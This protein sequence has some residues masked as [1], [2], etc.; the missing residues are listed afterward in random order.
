MFNE[1]L[2]ESFLDLVAGDVIARLGTDLANVVVVFPNIRAG[3]FF[4][5]SLYR[6]ANRPLW[7]PRYQSIESLF[8]S[9]ATL[10][11]G[12]NI[13]LTG[14]LYHTYI[15]VFNAHAAQPS[16][17]TLDEFFFF[18]EILLNDFDDVDKNLANVHSLFGNLQDLDRLK[19]DFAHLT[20]DQIKALMQ[21]FKHVFQ[22]ESVL[23]TAFH[24][25]WG[26]LGE[27]Y[28]TFKKKLETQ[29]I[30]YPG[31]LMRSVIENEENRFTGKQYVFA[32][33]NVLNRCE[34]RLFKQLK[35]K[36]LFY[37]DYDSYYLETEAGRFIKNNIRQ[38]GSALN[39][40]D[41]EVFSTK[42]KTITFLASPSENG[43]AAVVPLWIDSLN[44]PPSPARPD[45]AIV[46]C[47]EAILPAVM[48]AI[49]S[50]KVE[51]VNITMGFPIT[52][53]PVSSFLQALTEMQTL[54][55]Q[56]SGQSFRYKFVLPVLRHPY[57]TVLFPEAGAVER[58]IV[59]NNLFSPALDVLKN[60]LLFSFAEDTPALAAYLLA[61][62][63]KLG[64]CLG[65]GNTGAGAYNDLY[66]ESV[67]RAYQV[68]N[69]LSGLL[70]TGKWT[71]EKPT[72]LRLLRK[73]LST[74][75]IPFHGEPVKGL[76]I[77]GVL[78]TRS[79]DF[80]NILMLSVNEGFMPGSNSENTFIPQFLR[81]YFGLDT[82]DRQDSVY[83]YYFY[84]L[85]Q[86]AENLTF[87]YNTDKTQT[88]K[89]EISRFL[90]QLLIESPWKEKIVRRTL[91]S[92]VNPWTPQPI[93]I[94]KDG[95]LL[96][97]I[98]TQYDGTINPEAARLSPTAL[99]TLISCSFK[100][101]QQYIEGLRSK[102]EMS[103]ELD[104]SIFGSIFHRAAEYL[105][106]EIGH[107][108]EEIKKF[109]P[110]VV[111][112]EHFDPYLTAFYRIEK[113]VG[114]AFEREYF[115]GKPVN[116]QDFNGKQL[117][118]FRIIC[119]I[120]KRLIEFDSRR[121]PFT[122]H[123]LEYPVT[124]PFTLKNGIELKI[125]GIIDR[126]E[127]KDGSF[128]II[129]YKT[130]GKGKTYKTLEDLFIAKDNRASHIFQT[131]VYASALLQNEEFPL[132]IVPA[133]IYMQEA[134]KEDY[135]PVIL[136]NKEPIG[137]FRELNPEFEPLLKQ[138]IEA[139]FDPAIPFQQTEIA[140]VCEYCDFKEMCGRL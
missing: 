61:I 73:L 85:I 94:E 123:G 88:G 52:L 37:W 28:F 4:N 98:R 71:L 106:R 22:G 107:I 84:R 13:L 62:T 87:V 59:N 35:D 29:G 51:N 125:G 131:F 136:Y 66:V 99:N 90:L 68:I 140:G 116:P 112:K 114:R 20:D 129:D 6:Q 128:Y 75:K 111:R 26:I 124:S 103:D 74:V 47:N 7:A 65:K 113:L 67:F 32:G 40:P 31:M 95:N 96:Q 119:H 42:N 110:F 2:S 109:T 105:Y 57:T 83:A 97:R 86:R 104:N 24:N 36:A 127:E 101:Y 63:Q 5:Q 100:F 91:Q 30:A 23:K 78:E 102:E 43:Q 64:V 130:G 137:D 8:E 72:F 120:V 93:R 132:P 3:L 9:A 41:F 82:I 44:E 11:K 126:L 58:E 39:D 18:G 48:H 108:P 92:S 53:T 117:I 38:F 54:G 46:L 76:Q 10:R 115:K 15:E 80:K 121:A 27:V 45:S 33:F 134:G 89:S 25:I 56:T 122:L 17:E 70:A 135:S 16:A 14:E 79:L 12:D 55:R 19:D 138:T 69:R 60:E 133:L 81:Q 49:P 21:Y 1:K 50:E 139:L 118:T 77:M 34:E